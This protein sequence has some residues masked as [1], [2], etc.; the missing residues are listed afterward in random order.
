MK[1]ARDFRA[2]ARNALSGKW[3]VAVGAGL[4][5]TILGGTSSGS[6]SINTNSDEAEALAEQIL[7]NEQIMSVIVGVAVFLI[8]SLLLVMAVYIFIGGVVTVGYSKFNL[9]LV[10][11]RNMPKVS[12]LFAYFKH[13]KTAVAANVLKGL[14]IIL[15]TLLFFIPGVIAIYSYAMTGFVL[16]DNPELTAREALR[17]SKEI[18]RGNRWRLFCLEM[19]FFGWGLLCVLTLGIGLLWLRPYQNASYAAFY[20]EVSGTERILTTAE[21][22]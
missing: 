19:S 14:Y 4:I 11:G 13:W 21:Y 17:K 10:D 22:L 6:V 7:Q 2:I 15:G 3:G 8:L 16:A 18:M 9:D 5:A 1:R 20:R 12:T